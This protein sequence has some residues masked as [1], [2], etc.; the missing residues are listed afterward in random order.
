MSAFTQHLALRS[1]LAVSREKGSHVAKIGNAGIIRERLPCWQV[2][3]VTREDIADLALGHRHHKMNVNPVLEGCEEVKTSAPQFWLEAGFTVQRQETSLDRS[4]CTPQLFN[5]AN[6]IIGDVPNDASHP[7]GK[8]DHQ[9]HHNPDK[10][11]PKPTR[12]H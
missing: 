10:N 3:T 11:N 4:A 6:T 2:D 5:Y 7:N 9:Q 1:F 8:S 12:L